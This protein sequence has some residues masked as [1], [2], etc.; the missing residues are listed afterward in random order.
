MNFTV[1]NFNLAAELNLVFIMFSE[2][3]ECVLEGDD[4]F[5]YWR[6]IHFISVTHSECR[7]LS[8]LTEAQDSTNGP[9]RELIK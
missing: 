2:N 9:S 7:V 1:T 8:A 6:E 4:T 3:P 5:Y